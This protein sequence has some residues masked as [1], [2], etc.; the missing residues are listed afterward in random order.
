MPAHRPHGAGGRVARL[1]I[2]ADEATV[3]RPG[4]RRSPERAAPGPQRAAGPAE[5]G[6]EGLDRDRA[7]PLPYSAVSRRRPPASESARDPDGGGQKYTTCSD[8]VENFVRQALGAIGTAPVGRVLA[9]YTDRG[10]LRPGAG[11]NDDA[12]SRQR[13]PPDERTLLMHWD[14]ILGSRAPPV[15]RPDRA[16][17]LPGDLPVVLVLIRLFPCPSVR[18]CHRL[19][20]SVSVSCRAGYRRSSVHQQ[21]RRR[22]GRCPARDRPRRSEEGSALPHY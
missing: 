7:G 8:G 20:Q 17:M 6:R 18:L 5:A 4:I 22:R 2:S 16:R 11:Q 15:R 19:A 21:S 3:K 14:S 12:E 13:T 10:S 9:T 1:A